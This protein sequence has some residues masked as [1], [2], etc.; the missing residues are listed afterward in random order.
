MRILLIFITL[1]IA[2]CANPVNQSTADRYFK[3]GNGF[4]SKGQWFDA[5][6]AY[7]RAWTNATLGNLGDNATASYA[8]EYG[9]ASGAIC[10]WPESE[11]GLMKAL[12]IDKKIN[13][14]TY[15]DLVQLAFMF[16]AQGDLV[17]SNEYFSQ[18]LDSWEKA[19][20]E[21]RDPV[22]TGYIL[23]EYAEVLSRIIKPEE[24]KLISA[25][26][27]ELHR[28]YADKFEIN[29]DIVENSHKLHFPIGKYCGQKSIDPS[30]W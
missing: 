11:K 8:F 30:M 1:L 13:I 18:A 17:N 4:A 27:R 3:T 22:G 10:D 15:A 20:M 23:S 5:R 29:H 6:M 14:P 12:E 9:R 25:R 26:E 16:K 2:A 28:L 7:S 24:A 21:S 19:K